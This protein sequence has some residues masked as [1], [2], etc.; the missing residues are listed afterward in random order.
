MTEEVFESKVQ[1]LANN[2]ENGKEPDVTF[3]TTYRQKRDALDNA[4]DSIIV[5]DSSGKIIEETYFWL[6]DF[7]DEYAYVERSYWTYN[8]YECTYGRFTY[9]FD[10][11]TVVAT[12][13]SEFEQMILTWLT[14]EENQKIQ[15]ER[16]NF[17]NLQTEF[18]TYKSTYTTPDSEVQ[19]LKKFQTEKLDAEHKFAIEEV[20]SEFE[21]L[22]A[23][24]DFIALQDKAL[25]FSTENLE[26]E[27]LIIRGKAAKPTSAKKE[28]NQKLKFSFNKEDGEDNCPYGDIDKYIK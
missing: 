15:D 11:A 20:L 10:E 2:K 22:S 13:S 28:S 26:R 1:E 9:T 8:N 17:E 14:I 21:D 27:C 4:L 23:N 24:E 5:K 25:T 7:D 18:D 16:A 3:S 6:S 19:E 12:I